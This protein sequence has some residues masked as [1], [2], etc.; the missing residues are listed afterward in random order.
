MAKLLQWAV[1]PMACLVVL[2]AATPGSA[3]VKEKIYRSLT[4][5][6]VE[7]ILNEM[8]ISFKK[9]QPA[10]APKTYNFQF[11]RNSYEI[12]LSLNDGKRLWIMAFFPRAPLETINKWNI[13]A[14]FSRAVVDRV[15][16]KE[17]AIVEYQL[18]INGGAT[19]SMVKQFIARF[20]S[21]VAR[22]DQFLRN[23]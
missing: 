16:G 5:A 14:K 4:P 10:D 12:H 17:L 21:E 7:G 13:N 8:K 9:T 15:D 18:D 20:D 2:A 19:E 23:N 22:F 11:E 3:Q 6:Q 1:L